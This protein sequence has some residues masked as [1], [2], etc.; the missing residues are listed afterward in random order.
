MLWLFVH[1]IGDLK[2]LECA[3]NKNRKCIWRCMHRYERALCYLC[4]ESNCDDGMHLDSSLL[5]RTPPDSAC[6]GVPSTLSI[7]VL[8]VRDSSIRDA[9]FTPTTYKCLYAMVQQA[10]ATLD[11]NIRKC[12]AYVFTRAMSL[13]E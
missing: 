1:F 4:R 3:R 6:P 12:A 8:A 10:W 5:Q 9:E 2:C 11:A 7:L 13:P